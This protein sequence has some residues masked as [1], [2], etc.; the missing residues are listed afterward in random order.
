MSENEGR[1]PNLPLEALFRQPALEGG[2]ERLAREQ[3]PALVDAT[4]S[5]TPVH[6]LDQRRVLAPDLVVEGK[7]L[8]SHAGSAPGAKK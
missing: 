5:H 2:E 7:E 1:S 4:G 8:S 6:R 3:E